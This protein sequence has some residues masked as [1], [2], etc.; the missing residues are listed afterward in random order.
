MH[1]HMNVRNA[2][3]AFTSNLS[4][5]SFHLILFFQFLVKIVCL[6]SNCRPNFVLRHQF[7]IFMF[8]RRTKVKLRRVREPIIIG[9]KFP[10]FVIYEV[11]MFVFSDIAQIKVYFMIDS[12]W[13]IQSKMFKCCILIFSNLN[14]EINLMKNH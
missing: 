6:F 7:F 4:I 5:N 8:L 12:S 3:K 10:N 2:L 14:L 13:F 11:V 9:A 1:L